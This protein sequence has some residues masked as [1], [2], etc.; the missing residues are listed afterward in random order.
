MKP[1]PSPRKPYA[2]PTLRVYGS[3]KTLTAGGSPAA[4]SDTPGSNMM[5]PTS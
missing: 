2:P 5:Q 3:V 1:Q 4:L